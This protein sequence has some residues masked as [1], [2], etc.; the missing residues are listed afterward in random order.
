[1]KPRRKLIDLRCLDAWADSTATFNRGRR[2]SVRSA[3]PQSVA[4]TRE[5]FYLTTYEAVA[6][7]GDWDRPAQERRR[8]AITSPTERIPPCQA[9]LD[10]D[11]RG[12]RRWTGHLFAMSN[13]RARWSSLSTPISP[14]FAFDVIESTSFCHA[15]LSRL[16]ESSSA[17]AARSPPRAASSCVGRTSPRS[18]T[19]TI[20]ALRGRGRTE[21]GRSRSLPPRSAR[22]PSAHVVRPQSSLRSRLRCR[23]R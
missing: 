1:M 8:H 4:N 10:V 17:G 16:R 22:L 14:T 13:R 5:A 21:Q 23:G 9:A 6:T 20:P 18:S 15:R 12:E 19:Y 11:L 7:L 2:A 3:G